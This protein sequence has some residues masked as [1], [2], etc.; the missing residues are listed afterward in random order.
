M[1]NSSSAA[2][3]TATFG[4]DQNSNNGSAVSVE[5]TTAVPKSASLRA[6]LP[7]GTPRYGAVRRSVSAPR[8]L[9]PLLDQRPEE[10]AKGR[11]QERDHQEGASSAAGQPHGTA[12]TAMNGSSGDGGAGL[13]HIASDVR[14]PGLPSPTDSGSGCVVPSASTGNSSPGPYGSFVGTA[15]D[16]A[17]GSAR[18]SGPA[19]LGHAD[20]AGPTAPGGSGQGGMPPVASDGRAQPGQTPHSKNGGPVV[21]S[22]STGN[23]DH[24]TITGQRVGS[25]SAAHAAPGTI[26]PGIGA[27]ASGG[28]APGKGYHGY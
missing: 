24:G 21:A 16:A 8:P 26:T 28:T 27:A 6:P 2:N 14:V 11:S 23:T 15:L 4:G 19:N 9:L 7:A 20:G 5:V 3:S 10:L 13:S 22:A 17:L 12:A 1:E 25:A 18:P